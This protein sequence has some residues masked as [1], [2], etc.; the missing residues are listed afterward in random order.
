MKPLNAKA[1][2]A[3]LVGALFLL[4]MSWSL[5]G[6]L[7]SGAP[8]IAKPLF[9]PPRAAAEVVLRPLTTP[10]APENARKAMADTHA[11]TAPAADPVPERG[12]TPFRRVRV[13]GR[14]RCQFTPV[15]D[16]DVTFLNIDFPK[17]DDWDF[18]DEEGRY[19]VT[20]PPGR[21]DVFSAEDDE[22]TW[23]AR[24]IVPSDSVE[25][26]LDIEAP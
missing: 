4:A 19:E 26:G 17:V 12:G 18:T 2:L 23:L 8:D 16:R 14:L 21:Y 15:P 22:E 3:F 13:H 10:G 6:S 5:T 11:Q 7:G 24:V 25:L 9:L 1:S 20:V